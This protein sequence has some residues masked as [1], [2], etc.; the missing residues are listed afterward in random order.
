[1]ITLSPN[2]FTAFCKVLLGT[3]FSI[4]YPRLGSYFFDVS[5]PLAL[6]RAAAIYVRYFGDNQLIL[7][8]MLLLL[9]LLVILLLMLL[10]E[11][12]S[13]TTV[14]KH[15]PSSLDIF[16]PYSAVIPTEDDVSNDQRY[17]VTSHSFMFTL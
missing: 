1:M 4:K 6:L 15:D 5:G 16:L 3:L 17:D 13:D 2:F 14:P 9:L 12:T 8:L 11:G 10:E 7:G